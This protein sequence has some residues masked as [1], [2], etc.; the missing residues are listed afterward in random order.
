MKK[1][2]FFIILIL[3]SCFLAGFSP[4]NAGATK[5]DGNISGELN[6]GYR[7]IPVSNSDKNIHLNVYRGDYLKFKLKGFFQDP[8]LSIPALS[9]SEKIPESLEGAPYFKMKKAGTF[10]FTLGSV[11]G[12]ITVNDYQQPNYREVTS[13]EAAGFIKSDHPLILDVRTPAEYSRGHLK[14]A[15]LIPVQVLYAQLNELSA[16]KEKDILI[17]CATGNR[18]TVASKILL[19]SGFTKITNMRYGIVDWAAQKYPIII[20]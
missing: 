10:E 1:I 2:S 14:N 18:S 6:N 3:V 17:Y 9:I 11:N 19:D 16:Y 13:K 7:V 12:N 5:S 8:V 20:K 15:V 4:E